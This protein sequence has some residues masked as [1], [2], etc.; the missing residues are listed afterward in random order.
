MEV[1]DI[2]ASYFSLRAYAVPQDLGS[3]A[4]Q[5]VVDSISIQIYVY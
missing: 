5:K 3:F 2:G 4:R 1:V